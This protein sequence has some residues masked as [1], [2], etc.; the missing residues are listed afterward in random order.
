MVYVATGGYI[1]SYYSWTPPGLNKYSL[2]HTWLLLLPTLRLL[3]VAGGGSRFSSV[4]SAASS[5][6]LSV[7]FTTEFCPNLRIVANMTHDQWDNTENGLE[8]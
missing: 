1:G 2:L 4:F 6:M 8:G 7:E 5:A 3:V